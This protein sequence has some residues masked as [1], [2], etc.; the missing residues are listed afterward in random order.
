LFWLTL[1]GNATW[2]ISGAAA[3]SALPVMAGG[4]AALFSA[5]LI[6]SDVRGAGAVSYRDY[7]RWHRRWPFRNRYWENPRRS[8]RWAGTVLA[9]LGIFAIVIGF[10]RFVESSGS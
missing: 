4:I 6:F 1:A 9:L 2:A 7:I 10:L 3:W 8:F 5:Y